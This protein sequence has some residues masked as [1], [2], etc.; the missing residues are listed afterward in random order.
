MSDNG[1]LVLLKFEPELKG[2]SVI[3]DHVG[4]I[5]I[6][7]WS[8]GMTQSGSSHV[9]GGGGT[10]KVSVRDITV[11]KHVDSSSPNL[12]K[13]CC[14]GRHFTSATLTVYK[15]GEGAGDKMLQYFMVKMKDGLI[16]SLTTGEMDGSGR[17]VETVGLNFA[18]FELEYTP[19][20][21]SG[22]GSGKIPAKWNIAKNSES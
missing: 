14:N 20:A 18:A 3:K 22:S 8:W 19:Q 15:V 11:V 1:T 21:S 9:G 5:D 12:I 7:S 13:Q 17:M 16:S 4:E 6:L 10:G 2:E